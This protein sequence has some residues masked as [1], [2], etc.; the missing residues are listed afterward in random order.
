ME[1]ESRKN[2]RVAPCRRWLKR[3][4]EVKVREKEGQ[5]RETR[6][7]GGSGRGKKREIGD[8]ARECERVIKRRYMKQE[9][10]RGMKEKKLF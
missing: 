5:R 10:G 2:N 1:I 8:I 7:D 6:A 4:N 3:R 9:R